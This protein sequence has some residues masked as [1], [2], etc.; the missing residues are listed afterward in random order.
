MR[1]ATTSTCAISADNLG[2]LAEL[3]CAMYGRPI[4]VDGRERWQ[5]DP[6]LGADRAAAV[7]ARPE[8]ARPPRGGAASGDT[9]PAVR[10]NQARQALYADPLVRRIF[11]ELGA[12]LVEVR[13]TPTAVALRAVSEPKKS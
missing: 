11:D 9:R 2:V 3:A 13:D 5:R 4:R 6:R 12:R 1:R 8:A 10:R 7:P